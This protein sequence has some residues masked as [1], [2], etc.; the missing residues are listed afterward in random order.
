MKTNWSNW[1]K[2]NYAFFA[3]H[4]LPLPKHLILLDLGSGDLQ[5]GDIFKQFPYVEMDFK[6]FRPET[7]VVDFNRGI[8]LPDSTVDIITLSNTLEHI[9]DTVSFLKECHRVLKSGGTLIATVPFLLGEHQAP[10]DFNRYTH[11]QWER[12]LKDFTNV[13][14][15]PLGSQIDVYDSV[16]LKVFEFLRGSFIGEVVRTWRRLEMRLLRKLLGHIPA[17]YKMT[18]GYGIIVKK[19]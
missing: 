13:S 1:R 5:F 16:E 3:K 11:F 7:I 15:V 8:P 4:L 10:Y 17:G 14:V 18:E 6:Q 19:A 2:A 9:P 12:L